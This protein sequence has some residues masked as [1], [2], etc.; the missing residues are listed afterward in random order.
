LG[1]GQWR[2][3]PAPWTRFPDNQ[4]RLKRT[5]IETRLE[6]SVPKKGN[7]QAGE[8]TAYRSRQRHKFPGGLTSRVPIRGPRRNKPSPARCPRRVTVGTSVG[9]G[10]Q[11]QENRAKTTRCSPHPPPVK[12]K[13][14][15]NFQFSVAYRYQATHAETRGL[16]RQR[17]SPRSPA[18]S[19][20]P[21]Q[22]LLDDL[23]TLETWC[24]A[25][26]GS[27]VKVNRRGSNR[28]KCGVSYHLVPAK[29]RWIIIGF[30]RRFER[31][32]FA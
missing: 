26:I 13:R 32:A 10:N 18:M 20:N 17:E 30:N 31:K 21:D 8:N 7:P 16:K 5:R 14:H 6:A 25:P 3:K 29:D 2:G 28:R 22:V 23:K 4:I 12:L 15:A 11:N 27:L 19:E 24:K 9:M 1:S